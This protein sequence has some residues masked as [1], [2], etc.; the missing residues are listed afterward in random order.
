MVKISM[1]HKHVWMFGHTGW[2]RLQDDVNAKVFV[3][4][5]TKM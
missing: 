3:Q 2:K 1:S 4:Y 5:F